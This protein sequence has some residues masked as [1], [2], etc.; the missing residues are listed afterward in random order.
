MKLNGFIGASYK[1]KNRNVDS[2]RCVN[3]YPQLTESSQG[4]SQE[5]ASLVCT[6]GLSELVDL[7]AGVIRGQHV[8][9]NGFLYVV[10]GDSLYYIDSTWTA[11]KLGTLQT[12][13]GFVDFSNN[14][15]L[16]CLVDGANGYYHTISSRSFDRITDPDFLGSTTVNYIDGYFLFND[17]DTGVFYIAGLND[18]TFDALDFAQA[19]GLPDNI[20]ATSINHREVWLFGESSIEAWYNSGNAD[21]PF[22]RMGGGFIETGL[23]SAFSIAKVGRQTLFLGKDKEGQGIVYASQGLNP[24][25][26]STHA[27][28]EAINSYGDISNAIA[29]TYQEN[30][31]TFYILNFDNAKTSWCFDMATNLWHE[32]AYLENSEQTRH[33]ANFHSFAYR[34]HVVGDY[35]SGKLYKLDEDERTD[36]GQPIRRERIAPHI[37]ESTK[38]I[39]HKSFQLEVETG[40][41]SESE[42]PDVV[43]QWSDDGGYTWSNEK[44]ASLGLTGEFK[45][46]V[47]WRRLGSSRDR[48]YKVAIT[49]RVKADLISANLELELLRD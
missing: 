25:R 28:E 48:V 3:Y 5:V 1:L 31:H 6:A 11:L 14:G 20:I 10:C 45:K 26:I 7:G 36:N 30:G 39:S 4:K 49:S 33:L 15:T 43:L 37:S 23:A 12:S 2:Q 17:P 34:V 13:T 41:G 9:S 47:I 16:L 42:S 22:E 29:Y 19:S 35:S 46:R 24:V 40:Q 8:A 38:R 27:I 18:L 21:F 44:T 32:R